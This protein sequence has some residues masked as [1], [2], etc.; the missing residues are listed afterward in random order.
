MNLKRKKQKK[1]IAIAYMTALWTAQ[2]FSKKKPKPL[3][4]ILQIKTKK[5]MTDEEM[6]AQVK[7]LNAIFGGEVVREDG[8]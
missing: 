5:Q 8:N 7:N 4:E 1:K 6:L 3:D 2:W